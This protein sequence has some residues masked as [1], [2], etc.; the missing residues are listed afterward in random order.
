MAKQKNGAAVGQGDIS[1]R[2]LELNIPDSVRDTLAAHD[3]THVDQQTSVA[4]VSSAREPMRAELG[5][6]SDELG[7]VVDAARS[8]ASASA[9][10]AQ[11]QERSLGAL[12][13]PSSELMKVR[14]LPFA[15]T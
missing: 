7:T 14:S 10:A 8:R 15:S 2:L 5:I 11:P 4:Q 1:P 6:S 3:I 12:R 13:P 9:T